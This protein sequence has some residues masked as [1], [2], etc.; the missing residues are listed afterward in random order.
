MKILFIAAGF[1]FTA[2]GA[3]GVFLPILPTVPFLL[4]ASVC[5]AKGSEKVNRWFKSTSLYKNNL[6]EFQKSGS[7]TLKTKLCILLPVS[8]MLIFAFLMMHNIPGRVTII[9]L[10]VLKYYFFIFKIKT[11]K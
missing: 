6:E 1:L 10:I 4:L 3:V 5:F 8:V 2:L 7:M 11:Q 9:V